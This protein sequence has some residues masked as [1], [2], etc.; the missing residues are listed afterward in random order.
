[1]PTK[2]T[3]RNMG[4]NICTLDL[5]NT[6]YSD[7]GSWD[8]T[9]ITSSTARA[10]GSLSQINEY[11][12][13]F[14]GAYSDGKKYIIDNENNYTQVV[15]ALDAEAKIDSLV[16]ATNHQGAD[17]GFTSNRF[18]PYHL[19]YSLANSV[20]DLFVEGSSTTYDVYNTESNSFLTLNLTDNVT[21]KYV[22]VRMVCGVSALYPTTNFAATTSSN[23]GWAR[24]AN[25]SVNGTY[26]DPADA[27]V[28]VAK[29]TAV[30]EVGALTVSKEVSNV[31]NS[32]T[33][34]K[35]PEGS[36]TVSA[37]E[38][39]RDDE[40]GR[41]YTFTGW[42]NGET[43]VSANVNYTYNLADADINLTAKYEITALKYTLSFVDATKNVIGT[44]K[45][46]GAQ[47]PSETDVKAINA[48]VKDIYGYTVKLE[49]NMVVW[50]S[51]VF[52]AV[53][54]DKTFTACYEKKEIYTEVTLY[55]TDSNEH[56]Y[57][58][59]Q[60]FDTAITLSYEGAN[61][62]VDASGT[63][64]AATATATLYACGDAMDIYAKSGNAVAPEVTISGKVMDNGNF[65]VFAHA[66]PGKTVKAYGVIFASDLYRRNYDMQSDKGDMFTLKDTEAINKA[67]PSLKVSEVKVTNNANVDFMATLIGCE[68]KVRH[69][70]AYVIYS[71]DTVA[72][73]DVIVT[74]Y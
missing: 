66:T 59:T 68:N 24:M 56:F 55:K 40:N 35:Y 17:N 2:L 46:E 43:L 74:N 72:Y 8:L 10:A 28:T 50:D 36:A 42:Y 25:I 64:L 22:G 12:V 39:Y 3:A 61:S 51:E 6:K 49:D 34:G 21:A 9:A 65:T 58:E 52:E 16:W 38:S 4:N 33:N 60:E 69:A 20:N 48:K 62:W 30:A 37:T 53:T 18:T 27:N 32:D 31:G 63:V 67:S 26:V 19:K 13:R 1:M 29:D 15:Y 71:D 5:T 7:G 14:A 11:G 45:L 41:E 54:A 73:S 47:I 57:K 44:I 70:R 23:V